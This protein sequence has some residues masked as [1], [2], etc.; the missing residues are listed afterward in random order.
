[1]MKSI[2]TT[3]IMLLMAAFCQAQT[4]QWVKGG[5]GSNSGNI[6]TDDEQVRYMCTDNNKNTYVVS[7]IFTLSF[8]ADTFQV[9][10]GHY[11]SYQQIL[12]SSYR[13]DG[14][15]RWA[16][17]F[18][19]NAD[20]AIGG[21]VFDGANG[22]YMSGDNRGDGSLKYMGDGI[23]TMAYNNRRTFVVKYDTSG[24]QQWLQ[25]IGPASA[26]TLVN[27][28][29]FGLAMDGQGNV[30]NFVSAFAGQYITSSITSVKGCYDV[31][32]SSTG[33]LLS[34]LRLNVDSGYYLIS[35]PIISKKSN[36]LFTIVKQDPTFGSGAFLAAF[37]P[38]GNLIWKDTVG[39]LSTINAIIY[40]GNNAI[41]STHSG[42]GGQ[43]SFQGHSAVNSSYANGALG[44]I[45]KVDTNGS[46][47]WLFKNESRY[48]NGQIH[49]I[50]QLNS[51]TLIAGGNF[52]GKV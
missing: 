41:Y 33:M 18:E 1:M 26:T 50:A 32:Y 42:F 40:D 28:G 52:A 20:C 5:G 17:I 31:K 6:L 34:A 48:S 43:F 35:S 7:T 25:F 14:S 22:V 10:I 51:S 46:I 2:F 13:C 29:S 15:M 45:S 27:T 19:G 49:S 36:K 47:K 4:F 8:S 23:G 12:L 37:Y 3:A 30:H 24:T 39:N 16:R 38:N 11:P 9:P 44:L 21:L